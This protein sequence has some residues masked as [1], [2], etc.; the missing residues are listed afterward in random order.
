[1]DAIIANEYPVEECMTKIISHMMK[2][3]KASFDNGW[4]IKGD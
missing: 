4:L 2:F 3:E 1:M